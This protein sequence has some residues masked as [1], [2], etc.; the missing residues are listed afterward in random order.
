MTM[1]KNAQ[2]YLWSD[3]VLYLG[4]MPQSTHLSLGAPSFLVFLDGPAT[5]SL[6]SGSIS[7]QTFLVPAAS[8]MRI[9]KHAGRVAVLTLDNLGYEY[10]ALLPTMMARK[11]GVAWHSMTEKA[12]VQTFQMVAR[13]NYDA[14]DLYH[15]MASIVRPE[16]NFGQEHYQHDTRIEKVMALVR[17]YGDTSL[18]IEDFSQ[19]VGLTVAELAALFQEK[20]GQSIQ[21][22]RAWCLLGDVVTHMAEGSAVDK[23]AVEA[24]FESEEQ[25]FKVFARHIGVHPRALATQIPATDIHIYKKVYTEE[26]PKSSLYSA[27][28]FLA[29]G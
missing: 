19:Q 21:A 12:V 29:F 15:W 28:D 11:G 14:K 2:L 17:R 18:D 6:E 7:A 27:P 4:T 9:Q 16:T 5:L 13:G 26:E 1:Q 25:Y 3:R 23:A 20:V 22:F 8:L 24:G 10:H